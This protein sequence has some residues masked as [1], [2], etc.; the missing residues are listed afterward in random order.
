MGCSSG[1]LSEIL[2]ACLEVLVILLCWCWFS[3]AIAAIE[4]SGFILEFKQQEFRYC[5]D[6]FVHWTATD[7]LLVVSLMLS[8]IYI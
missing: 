5:G 7:A 6:R 2:M 1:Q 3:V 4:P 8:Q